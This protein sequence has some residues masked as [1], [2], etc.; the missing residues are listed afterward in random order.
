MP[1]KIDF[2]SDFTKKLLKLN[3]SKITTKVHTIVLVLASNSR[4][5]SLRLHK[6]KGSHYWSVSVNMSLRIILSIEE[7]HVYLLDIGTHDE[8]Y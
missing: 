5:P 6:L 4:H 1:Y 2:S 3:N 8:V 7:N